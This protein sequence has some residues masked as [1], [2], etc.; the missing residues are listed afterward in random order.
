ENKN[1]EENVNA[2]M[3]ADDKNEDHDNEEMPD[4]MARTVSDANNDNDPEDEGEDD[5][6][7][8]YENDEKGI[9]FADDG[10]RLFYDADETELAEDAE[11]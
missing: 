11:P 3:I 5:N 1:N 7:E 10:G 8:D 6:S 2:D 4:L 9:D